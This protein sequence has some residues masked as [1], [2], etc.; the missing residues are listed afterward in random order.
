MT[1]TN[2]Q[3]G[4][5][6]MP[7]QTDDGFRAFVVCLCF[8]FFFFSFHQ[9][10]NKTKSG[11]KSHFPKDQCFSLWPPYRFPSP[12]PKAFAVGHCWQGHAVV[13]KWLLWCSMAVPVLPSDIVKK[14][15]ELLHSQIRFY[16]NKI[17]IL[18]LLPT[19]RC[20]KTSPPFNLPPKV[21]HLWRW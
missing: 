11:R 1:C 4:K 7:S 12:S 6:K 9:V 17:F 10:K 19:S 20:R 18:I 21:T 2:F 16:W 3:K 14:G 5:P 8:V 15:A 13:D